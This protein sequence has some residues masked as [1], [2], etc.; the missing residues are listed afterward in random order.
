MSAEPLIVKPYR[1]RGKG[2]VQW[3]VGSDDLRCRAYA[4]ERWYNRAHEVQVLS[5]VEV[6]TEMSGVI[7]ATPHYHLS[8][9]KLVYLAYRPERCSSAK[10]RWVLEEFGMD[11]ALEDNHVAHGIVRNFWRP[12]A[13]PSVGKQCPCVDEEPAIREDKGDYIWRGAR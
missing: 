9:S 5:A 1:P 11:G 4:I 10:A 7:P 2:W 13:E 3:D 6:S 12:V 8:I